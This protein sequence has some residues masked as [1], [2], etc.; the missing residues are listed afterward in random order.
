MWSPTPRGLSFRARFLAVL[1][2]RAA[3]SAPAEGVVRPVTGDSDSGG[4]GGTCSGGGFL[5]A[6]RRLP[7]LG[8]LLA[9]AAA[10]AAAGGGCLALGTAACLFLRNPVLR[11]KATFA[12]MGS[13]GGAEKSTWAARASSAEILFMARPRGAADCDG[14]VRE[15]G[16]EEGRRGA[17]RLDRS[18]ARMVHAGGKRGT[19]GRR[20]LSLTTCCPLT[21]SAGTRACEQHDDP[22]ASQPVAEVAAIP[23]NA[24]AADP[25]ARSLPVTVFTGPSLLSQSA[26]HPLSPVRL[27][28]SSHSSAAAANP[29]AV[30]ARPS[31]TAR[32]EPVHPAAPG[33][34]FSLFVFFSPV[35]HERGRRGEQPVAFLTPFSSHEGAGGG[36][37]IP[38]LSACLPACTHLSPRGELRA[39]AVGG[40]PGERLRPQR[41]SL[42]YF[43]HATGLESET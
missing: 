30:S 22:K 3:A 26:A 13:T 27:A 18:R 5:L 32:G 42:N 43:S 10:A 17:K 12:E 7:L 15:G 6:G 16:A 1:A 14:C 31:K 24:G 11:P 35:S 29:L 36:E 39:S 2:A 33:K 21:S 20:E 4:G 40:V 25:K 34:G 37:S 8:L 9:A 23:R 19:R 38:A 41:I 28:A